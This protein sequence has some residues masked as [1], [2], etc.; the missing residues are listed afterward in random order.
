MPL[1]LATRTVL[2]RVLARTRAGFRRA[3]LPRWRGR[4][5]HS[6]EL[7][8]SATAWA[9][10]RSEQNSGGIAEGCGLESALLGLFL[11]HGVAS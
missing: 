3:P 2:A 10:M 11:L 1:M 5:T 6:A 8:V 7:D 4:R 9:A